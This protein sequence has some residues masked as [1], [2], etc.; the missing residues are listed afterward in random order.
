MLDLQTISDRI[1][2]DDL[3]HDLY[4]LRRHPRLGAFR[5]GLHA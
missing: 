2:I 3:N 1:E 4:A 5:H